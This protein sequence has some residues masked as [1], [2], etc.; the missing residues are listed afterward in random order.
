MQELANITWADGQV[1]DA[2][3]N[4]IYNRPRVERGDESG[5]ERLPGHSANVE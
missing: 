3:Q 4:Y 5:D 2:S 1:F